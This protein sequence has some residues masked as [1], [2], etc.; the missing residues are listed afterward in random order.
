MVGFWS[1]IEGALLGAFV[2]LVIDEIAGYFATRYVLKFV[3]DFD[4]DY[5][6][7]IYLFA[8][9]KNANAT[10]GIAFLIISLIYLFL[11]H[12][13]NFWIGFGIG[14]GIAPIISLVSASF[15]SYKKS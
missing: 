13:F 2:A 8:Y 11:F 4:E 3:D 9:F 5:L 10:F 6:S 7:W 12:M 14:Y 1:M 15:V